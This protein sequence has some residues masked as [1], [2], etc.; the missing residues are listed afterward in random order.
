MPNNNNK[1]PPQTLTLTLLLF[2]LLPTHSASTAHPKSHSTQLQDLPLITLHKTDQT[3]LLPLTINH[4]SLKLAA[5]LHS[6]RTWIKEALCNL[7]DI[8]TE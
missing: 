6:V 2:L 1:L 8:T 3:Y 7:C 5:Q 4:H